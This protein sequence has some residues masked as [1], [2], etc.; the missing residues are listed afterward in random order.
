MVEICSAKAQV[1]QNDRNYTLF[2]A[3]NQKMCFGAFKYEPLIED[4]IKCH[5]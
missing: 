1:N 5:Y 4:Q 3:M 2:E